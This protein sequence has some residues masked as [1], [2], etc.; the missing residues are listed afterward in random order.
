VLMRVVRAQSQV[1]CP[2]SVDSST[3]SIELTPHR[4]SLVVRPSGWP[5]GIPW[6]WRRTCAHSAKP[7]RH[8]CPPRPRHHLL[9]AHVMPDPV[10]ATHAEV[11]LCACSP[12]FRSSFWRDVLY[13]RDERGSE[14]CR[15]YARDV[16][17]PAASCEAV[18]MV[19]SDTY[20]RPDGPTATRSRRGGAVRR[21][22]RQPGAPPAREGKTRQRQP[23]YSPSISGSGA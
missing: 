16:D 10:A 6:A 2:F 22:T 17:I 1:A 5:L 21:A 20:R 13:C 18:A 15:G 9:G 8:G 4:A 19:R 11:P 23:T 14:D 7:R 3:S 12:V